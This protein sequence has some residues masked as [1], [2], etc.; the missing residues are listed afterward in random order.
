MTY[1]DL[2]EAEQAYWNEYTGL[3]ALA[4]WPGFDATMKAAKDASRKWLVDKRAEIERLAQTKAKGGDGGGWKKNGR[5]ARFEFL[6]DNNLN[7][8]APKHEVRLPAPGGATDSEKVYIEAREI[9]LAFASTTDEQKARKQ[10]NVDW[11]V[12]RRKQLH[13][14]LKSADAKSNDT[15]HR[16]DRYDALCVAT[17]YGKVYTAWDKAHN[18]W[19]VPVHAEAAAGGQRAEIVRR[20]RSYVGVVEHPAGSNKGTPQ[21]SEWERRVVGSD[22]WAW[23]ACFTVSMTWDAGVKGVG[24]AGVFNNMQLAKQGKGMFSAFTT[25]YRRVRPGDHVI[26]GCESCHTEIVRDFPTAD[27]CPTV[28]GNTSPA[29]GSG[30]EYNGG[31][32]AERTRARHE[33]VGYCLVRA[34]S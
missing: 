13:G 14:L 9:Y 30:S 17:H 32:V 11:L 23:C 16:Q 20:A 6:S 34:T 1:S 7:T 33:I 21:P 29:P 28:G 18:K 22:G 2:T 3:R 8:G 12:A 5:K 24:T 19:G 25:D 26:V 4:D 31:C 27:E 10:A 15:N